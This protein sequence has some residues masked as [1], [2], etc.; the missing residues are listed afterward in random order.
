MLFAD[1]AARD[2][3]EW[4]RFRR[5][6][7]G[8]GTSMEKMWR[9][10]PTP[11]MSFLCGP[12]AWRVMRAHAYASAGLRLRTAAELPRP[13]IVILGGNPKSSHPERRQIINKDQLIPALRTR[14]SG[15]DIDVVEMRDLSVPQQLAEL[16]RTS[17][18]VS[19]LGSKSFRLVMLPDGAQACPPLIQCLD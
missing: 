6:V 17:V 1:K 2:G 3:I 12:R 8:H 4:L 10:L 15:V 9:S 11:L 13:R 5:L 14:F 19:P 7:A 16:S 18:L